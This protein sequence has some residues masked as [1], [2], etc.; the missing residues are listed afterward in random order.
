MF[1]FNTLKVNTD[2][3][4]VLRIIDLNESMQTSWQQRLKCNRAQGNTF[5]HLKFIAEN[6][7]QPKFPK[8]AGERYKERLEQHN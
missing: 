5:R 3:E 8:D 1:N 7:P 6:I 4:Y 2:T